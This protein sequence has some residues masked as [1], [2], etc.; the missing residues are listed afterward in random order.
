MGLPVEVNPLF[1]ENQYAIQRSLR[2]R[3]SATAYL[4]RTFGTPTNNKIWTWSGW[5]KRGL[6]SS[7]DDRVLFA[8]SSGTNVSEIFYNGS[9][10]TLRFIDYNG[11]SYGAQLQSAAVYRDF[12][13]WYHVTVIFDSTSA[14]STIT[15]SSTDR[16]RFYVNGA[17]IT[18][19][20]GTTTVPTLNYN[21]YINS[22]I[23][24]VIGKDGRSSSSGYFDG[25]LAEVNFIDGLALTPSSFGQYNEFGVWSP[26]KY[27]GSYGNNGFYL[28]FT[29]ISSETNILTG[30]NGLGKDFSGNGNF[31]TTNNISL[32]GS[33]VTSF[34]STGATTWT[35]P[36]GVTSIRYLVVAG[37]GG[38]GKFGGGGGG[39]GV[40]TG[41][42]AVTPGTIYTMTVGAGGAGS[43]SR[44][45]NG[46]NGSTS[47]ISGS[48]ISTI[49]ATGGGGGGSYNIG[50]GS[51][52]G[53]GGGS[54]GGATVS[55]G[56]ASPSGQG[57]T[58][59]GL[60]GTAYGGGG[61]GGGAVGQTATSV[62]TGGN[63]GAGIPSTLTGSTVSYSGGG[64]GTGDTTAGTGGA[65]GGGAGST[66]NSNGT[67]GTA[68]T[69]GGGGG[70]RDNA[71]SGGSGGAGGSG[72]IIIAYG[73]GT[74]YD[75]MTDVPTPSTIQNVAAGNYAVA[76]PNAKNTNITISN[77]NLTVTSDAT[78]NWRSGG[79]TF[80]NI[81]S[82]K[83]YYEA[84][85]TT[86]SSTA[87]V[88]VGWQST[89]ADQTTQSNGVGAGA[90]NSFGLLMNT[91]LRQTKANGSIIA[92]DTN[93]NASG[94]II[95]VAVDFD[96]SKAWLGKNGTWYD[97][98]NPS[99]GAN[100]IATV[101]SG[102]LSPAYQTYNAAVLNINFGQRPFAYT[103]PSGFLPLNTNNLPSPTIPNGARVMAATLYTG[104]GTSLTVYNSANNTTGVTFQPDFIWAK[105]RGAATNN[106]L[107]DVVRG[108][109]KYLASDATAS[110]QIAGN[111]MTSFNIDGFSVGNDSQWNGVTTLVGWQW[112]AGGSTPTTGTGTG[113]ITNVQ[114]SANVS[115]GFSIVTYTGSGANG[116]VTHGLGVAP[117]MVIV[118][119]RSSTGSWP[120]YHSNLTSAA[121]Y[122]TLN[123]T[124]AQ[125][126]ASTVWN[127]TAPTSSVFS[128]G[129]DVDVNASSATYV[130]YCFAP[131][132]GYSSMGS[133]T[134]NA[135]TDG[136]MVFLNFR[137]RFV[138]LKNTTR[139]LDW[140]TYDSSRDLY[141]TETQQLYPNLSSAE[142]AGANIDFLS[143]G[144]K[145]R[146]ASG[147]GINNTS[148]DV[149]IYAAFAENPFKFALAR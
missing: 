47:S 140:I 27:G 62:G 71:G 77:G 56:A 45:S 28:P 88:S 5:V 76:N 84:T 148:G 85:A 118:K 23:A 135:S 21:T 58:G 105:A 49:T 54:A 123:T 115:A 149:Y 124:N 143:N 117:S 104:N 86:I 101:L 74:T 114:Y 69:G 35:A 20:T 133:Y 65:G 7:A 25:Y 11:S 110:E 70:S 145:I 34:T 36:S 31:W 147:S 120:I 52:G 19:F 139:I 68:N 142:A 144:F 80:G 121:Y 93:T 9:L 99:T 26:R 33:T 38:G 53:S 3:A 92:S 72:V 146:G 94:D 39:G 48:D 130:A 102:G 141:N 60:T 75:A 16:I 15:G 89:S 113:G 32:S 96:N 40:L 73:S 125:L 103:P 50:Q 111:R 42:L 57:N 29:D 30:N 51:S 112:K 8:A 64:G 18:T 79:A 12:S 116:T 2:F 91:S 55:G 81:T 109:D 41:T 138:L 1:L 83:W 122:V 87:Y 24:H 98:G 126:S 108:Y 107:V 90:N 17:Q 128:I 136:P 37:G 95:M 78:T 43:T 134:A 61:G 129:T 119:R 22:N 132:S 44:S 4:N 59:G 97:S 131:V 46:T 100:P 10:D 127:S 66:G 137:P 82:G 13:S 63:G 67:A 14:T 106:Q 6:N